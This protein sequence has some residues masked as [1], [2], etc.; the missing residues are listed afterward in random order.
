[1]FL[2]DRAWLRQLR[3]LKGSHRKLKQLFAVLDKSLQFH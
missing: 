1:M 3:W 2:D